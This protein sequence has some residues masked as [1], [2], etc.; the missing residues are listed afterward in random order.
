[1]AALPTTRFVPGPVFDNISLDLMGPFII[2]DA[3][4][5]RLS[6]KTWI[7]VYVCHASGATAMEVMENYST[8]SFLIAFRK[9]ICLSVL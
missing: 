8:D 5:K 1:M 2:K 9:Y 4:K 7:V 3:V 6:G